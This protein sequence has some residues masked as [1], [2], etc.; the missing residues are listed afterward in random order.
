MVQC[1]EAMVAQAR[2]GPHC[3]LDAPDVRGRAQLEG[4]VRKEADMAAAVVALCAQLRAV[5]GGVQV[6]LIHAMRIR[7]LYALQQLMAVR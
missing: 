3:L 4:R 7:A 2:Q 6:A 1:F 5:L